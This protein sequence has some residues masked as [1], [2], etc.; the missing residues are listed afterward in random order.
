MK[1]QTNRIVLAMF[2]TALLWIATCNLNAQSLS[3]R[4]NV[5]LDETSSFEK[6]SVRILDMNT[7][8]VV[9]FD[10]VKKFNYNL[11]YNHMYMVVVSKKGYE[12]KSIYIDTKCSTKESFKFLFD[13]NLVSNKDDQFVVQAGGIFFNKNKKEFDFFYN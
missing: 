7:D 10:A 13:M 4:G 8:S 11:E 6:Y 1:N 5:T 2:A 3:I 9:K 12:S